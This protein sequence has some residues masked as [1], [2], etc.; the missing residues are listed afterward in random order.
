MIVATGMPFS[1]P[2]CCGPGLSW[3]A[4]LFPEATSAML[5]VLTLSGAFPVPA[6]YPGVLTLL[7]V[8]LDGLPGEFSG[9]MLSAGLTC[10]LP[11]IPGPASFA[12]PLSPAALSPVTGGA[13]RC[14]GLDGTTTVDGSGRL[15]MIGVGVY[16]EVCE[17]QM[18]VVFEYVGAADLLVGAVPEVAVS[19][20]LEYVG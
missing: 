10:W 19:T 17:V 11:L 6:L 14:S 12:G 4:A 20:M 15:S 8:L 3:Y 13:T 2:Y 18:P 16:S 5:G 1:A 9:M 7:G